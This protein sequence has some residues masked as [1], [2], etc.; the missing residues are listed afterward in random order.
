MKS[1]KQIWIAALCLLSAT[2]ITISLRA[3]STGALAPQHSVARALA[4]PA[5]YIA[6]TSLRAG[7]IS[8]ALLLDTGAVGRVS[9]AKQRNSNPLLPP[10]EEFTLT[11][12]N[13]ALNIT[14]TTVAVRFPELSAEKLASL[15]PM[16]LGTQSVVLQRSSDDPRVFFHAGGI[17]LASL[18]QGA[19]AAEGRC[20]PGE[21]G[22]R[23]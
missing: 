7:V 19:G 23:I 9:T 20:Q 14:K 11:P 18:R 8:D 13:P 12:P 3:R 16:N 17:Q 4:Q 2:V 22:F 10:V 15:I 1:R 21:D 6:N 5:A